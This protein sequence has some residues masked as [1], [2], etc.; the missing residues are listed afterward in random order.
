MQPQAIGRIIL[1]K[2]PFITP[3]ISQIVEE[4]T[5]LRLDCQAKGSPLPRVS[6][7][8]ANGQPFPLPGSP[9][10]VQVQSTQIFV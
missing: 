7:V 4:G 3:I 1:Q 10:R 5:E 8:K 6:W 2:A 9:Q